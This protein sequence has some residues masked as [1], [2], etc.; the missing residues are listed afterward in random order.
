MDNTN[1]KS[2][3]FDKNTDNIKETAS[4]LLRE[5]KKL[6]NDIYHEGTD[7]VSEKVGEVEETISEYSDELIKKIRT[8]PLS[9]VLIAAGVGAIITLMY[10]K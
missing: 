9:A 5:G 6:V 2:G 7:K 10:K 4:E 1:F 8:N 3:N